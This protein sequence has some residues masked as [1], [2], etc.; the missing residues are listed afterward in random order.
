[1]PSIVSF[2]TKINGYLSNNTFTVEYYQIMWVSVF[3]T[4]SE[5]RRLSHIM[6]GK[7][8][9]SVWLTRHFMFL[10]LR[11]REGL[12]AYHYK[13]KIDCCR[14]NP[15]QACLSEIATDRNRS[16]FRYNRL[17]LFIC[18]IGCNY[19]VLSSPPHAPRSGAHWPNRMEYSHRFLG[20]KFVLAVQRTASLFKSCLLFFFSTKI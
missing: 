17:C 8:H 1:M 7:G 14:G 12:H 2:P 3:T 10:L 11:T 18:W 9:I 15:F 6:L 5:Q 16:R 19:P 13:I 20:D 4:I